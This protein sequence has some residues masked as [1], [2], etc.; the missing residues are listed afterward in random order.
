MGDT[1][2]RKTRMTQEGDLREGKIMIPM[3][4]IPNYDDIS[5]TWETHL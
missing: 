3:G 1:S 4:D 2:V 5:G